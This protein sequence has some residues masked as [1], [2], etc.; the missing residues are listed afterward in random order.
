MFAARMSI[1]VRFGHKDDFI[2]LHKKWMENVG[3]KVGVD[4]YNPRFLNGSI[5]A[6]ESRF[7]IEFEVESLAELENTFAKLAQQPY[8]KEW[9]KEIEPHVVSGS[10]VWE[11]YRVLK[12]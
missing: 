6:K 4:K 1:D 3:M 8:H 5:G 7:E 10:N 9:G 11:I 2:E 12:L